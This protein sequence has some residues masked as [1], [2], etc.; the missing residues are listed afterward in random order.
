M[1]SSLN[2][3]GEWRGVYNFQFGLFWMMERSLKYPVWIILEKGESR[4]LNDAPC[5]RTSLERATAWECLIAWSNMQLS[6]Q[7]LRLHVN[8][9][10]S[11]SM[12]DSLYNG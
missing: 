8:L 1:I 12:P 6:I 10:P 7:M 2:Y 3:S 5:F 9:E 4:G 11:Y